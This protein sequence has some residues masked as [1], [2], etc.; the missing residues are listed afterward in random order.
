MAIPIRL[1]LGWP[2]RHRALEADM[3]CFES[4]AGAHDESG[5]AIF[6]PIGPVFVFQAH[7]MIVGPGRRSG[8]VLDASQILL[9]QIAVTG[10]RA[11]GVK[12]GIAAGISL[13]L[14]Q[15][16]EHMTGGG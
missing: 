3:N 10:K 2:G 14:E 5:P 12:N 13:A 6:K 16:G 9:V 15:P 8:T 4:L 11:V 7:K 1:T